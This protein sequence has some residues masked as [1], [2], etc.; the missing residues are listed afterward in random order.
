MDM[1][2]D[3]LSQ[4]FID[5]VCQ[6]KPVIEKIT[7]Y[8]EQGANINYQQ[9]NNGYT[10][11]MLATD[12]QDE[13][14]VFF[15][16]QNGADPL[17]QNQQGN[18]A[19][20]LVLTTSPIYQ[21]LKNHE[22][23]FATHNN[24]IEK[25]NAILSEG[26]NIDAR[27]ANGNT[28]FLI[29]AK[30]N[31]LGLV[32]F[33]LVHGA[34]TSVKNNEGFSALFLA[35]DP[36]VRLTLENGM[37]FSEEEKKEYQQYQ[38]EQLDWGRFERWRQKTLAE[39]QGKP[40]SLSMLK[41]Y[42][43]DKRPRAIPDKEQ[44][45]EIERHYGH[46]LPEALC[47]IYKNYNGYRPMLNLFGDEGEERISNFYEFDTDRN[48]FG[49]VWWMI[50]NYSSLLGDNT[51]PFAADSF[52]GIYFLKWLEGKSQVWFFQSDDRYIDD[53]GDKFRFVCCSLDEFL[54]GLY[55]GQN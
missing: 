29:S 10:A 25:V 1:L 42:P 38:T 7:Q 53:D 40:F 45:L 8:L 2:N 39:R 44:L 36:L 31:F 18:V 27:D 3:L 41:M 54:E 43:L 19:S 9:S 55:E 16:L 15:L 35:I 34:N 26:A 22:L 32:E 30:N 46:P 24:D 21:L 6:E 23:L 50:N 17:I 13:R 11:L 37:P 12:R 52:H 47:E 4:Q 20:E 14:L 28:S 33:F 5:E 49:T 51:L 48:R